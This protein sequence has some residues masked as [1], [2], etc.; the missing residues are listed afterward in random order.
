[1]FKRILAFCLITIILVACFSACA[2]KQPSIF[3]EDD[4]VNFRGNTFTVYSESEWFPVKRKRGESASTDRFL[5]RIE[6]IEKNYN[7]IISNNYG[8]IESKILAMS[9]NG[10][11]GVDMITCGNDVLF[12]FYSLGILTPFSEIGVD[13]D[14]AIKFGIPSLLVEGTFGG[15]QYGIVN[16]L[17]DAI[18]SFNGLISINMDLLSE[19]SM[20]DPHEYEE[21]G[22]WNWENLRVVLNQGTFTDGEIQHVGMVSDYPTPGARAFFG[23]ILTNGG[24]IIKEID[25]VYKSGLCETNAIEAIEFM[26]G[27]VNDGLLNIG[28]SG[29]CDDIWKEGKTWPLKNDGGIMNNTESE[30]EYSVVRFPYGPSGNK[31]LVAAYSFN[32]SYY[33]FPIL[34]AFAGDETGIIVDDLFEP[35]DTSLY[36][37]G[38]KDYARDNLF[39][40]DSDFDTF[41]TG[42]NNLN[43]YPIGVLYGTNPWT[44]TGEVENTMDEIL[45]GRLTAQAGMDSVK[46]ILQELIDEKLNG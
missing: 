30:I 21:K 11:G 35:L 38:W 46:D 22:E 32:R 39:Y 13:D 1:M 45:F 18:P 44:N 14:E 2:P 15:T 7:V 43:Y 3:E 12:N 20:T 28:P 9:L 26:T 8:N 25:G 41:M 10:G 16:Y 23:A 33:A 34:S 29:S 42:L 17:G 27:L 5:D 6:Q 19:L 40:S 37:E 4:E 31:D 24:Y 36:P